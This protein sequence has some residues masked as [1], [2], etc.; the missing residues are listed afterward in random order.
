MKAISY[1][2]KLVELLPM[3]EILVKMNSSAVDD[4]LLSLGH[5]LKDDQDLIEELAEWLTLLP[6][7]EAKQVP[8]K[9]SDMQFSLAMLRDALRDV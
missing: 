4:W 5:R 7:F 2:N 9:L 1:L 8:E 6:G 3:L